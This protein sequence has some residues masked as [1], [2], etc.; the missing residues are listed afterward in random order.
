MANLVRLHRHRLGSRRLRRRD[1]RRPARHEDRGASRRTQVGGR[2]LNYACIPAKAVLRVGRR[3]A[4]GPRRRRVR[5]QGRASRTVDFGAVTARRA[6]VIKTLT[7]GVAGLF[8]KNGIDVIEGHGV[9]DRRRQRRRSADSTA[10]ARGRK[11]I[12][13]ATGSVKRPIPGTKFGGRVIGTEEAWAL[14]RAARARSRSSARARRAPRSPQRYARLGAE[15][16]L[17]E[18]LDRVLPTE[19]ADIS[20]ARRARLQEAG[21]RGPHEDVRRGRRRRATSSV[22]VHLRRRAGRGRLARHRRR[23]RPRRRG[24]R[25]RRGRRRAR[26]ARP[27]QGRRRAAHVAPRVYAIGDLVP[28]P[29]LAHKASDE[30]IIAVEDAAGLETAPARLRRHPARDVLHAERRRPSG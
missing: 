7:G 20:K 17:F 12:I 3:P 27:D 14:E 6:K 19:D 18:G 25:P 23:P 16:L 22:H 21:H 11:A 1:P 28:G 15:V 5:H 2:C 4:G 26:R 9:A 29:A 13:L 24:P 8:K 10:G 30:G